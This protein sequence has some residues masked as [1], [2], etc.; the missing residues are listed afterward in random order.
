MCQRQRFRRH[1]VLADTARLNKDTAFTLDERVAL[2]AGWLGCP[3][4]GRT[5]AQQSRR[6]Y[7]HSAKRRTTSNGIS[8]FAPLRKNT[9]ETL[10]YRLLLAPSQ[11]NACHF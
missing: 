1:A 3:P 4:V 7:W 5:L 8:I 2:G 10:F 6:C 11:Q 9:D